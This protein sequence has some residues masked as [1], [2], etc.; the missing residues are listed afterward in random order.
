[1]TN[2]CDYAGNR[3]DALIGY[4]YGELDP[5]ELAAFESHIAECA[6]CRDEAAAFRGVRA[7]LRMWTP[8]A[9]NALVTLAPNRPGS[10]RWWRDIPVWAQIAVPSLCVGVAGGLANVNVRYSGGTLTLRTGWARSPAADPE[11][12]AKAASVSVA[13]QAPWRGDLA[14][15]DRQLRSDFQISAG[16]ARSASTLAQSAGSDEVLKRVR[17]L[18]AESERRQQRELALRVA[19]VFKDVQTLRQ[20]DLVKIDRSLNVLQNNTGME[21]M[22]QRQMINSL[23]V[24]VSQRP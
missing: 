18:V 4:L 20:A 14:T 13:A 5:G 2:S 1:M 16:A 23:A 8:P 7:E 19:E 21:V 11:S 12:A 6:E 3:E 15:L 9:A 17:A 22:K 10:G 24:R